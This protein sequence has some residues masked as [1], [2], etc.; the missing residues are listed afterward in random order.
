MSSLN[1]IAGFNIII[2]AIFLW[3]M[4]SYIFHW[5]ML[6]EEE[7]IVQNAPKWLLY[8]LTILFCFMLL[9]VLAVN[10]GFLPASEQESIYRFTDASFMAWI[11][12]ALYT[13]WNWGIH[14]EDQAKRVRNQKQ[15]FLLLVILV[16]LFSLL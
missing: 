8:P 4:K 5:K 14:V 10:L 3:F 11:C 12:L 6:T 1:Q 7:F 13:K 15:M 16:F 9:L 2:L